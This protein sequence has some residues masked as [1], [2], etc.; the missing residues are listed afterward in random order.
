MA[1]GSRALGSGPVSPEM[2]PS[3]IA[4]HATLFAN[5]PIE[6]SEDASGKVPAS[7]T[8]RCVGLNPTTPHIAAGILHEP[9][10]SVPS[11]AKHISSAIDTAAPLDEPPG[12]RAALR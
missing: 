8:R 6:S 11:P 1:L 4:Q 9:P 12:I 10:V 7:G 3:M 2:I 5:G